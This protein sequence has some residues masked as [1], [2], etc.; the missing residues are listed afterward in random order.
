MQKIIVQRTRSSCNCGECRVPYM[1]NYPHGPV[2]EFA[3]VEEAQAKVD[4]MVEKEYRGRTWEVLVFESSTP[5]SK[6][7]AKDE[8]RVQGWGA[9]ASG[10]GAGWKPVGVDDGFYSDEEDEDEEGEEA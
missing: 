1:E 8:A 4:E 3:T 6:T 5:Y 7:G 2:K 10:E 9:G